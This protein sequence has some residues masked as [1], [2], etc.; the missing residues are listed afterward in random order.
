MK[1]PRVQ[2][3]QDLPRDI[4]EKGIRTNYDTYTA[5]FEIEIADQSLPG[6]H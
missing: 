4:D 5:F 3:I 1:D 2:N 6:N